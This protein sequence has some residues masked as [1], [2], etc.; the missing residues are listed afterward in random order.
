MENAYMERI[1][2]QQERE[3]HRFYGKYRGEVYEVGSGDN[4]GCIR[5][6]VPTVFGDD[7]ISGWAYPASPY[8][9]DGYGL[10]LMPETGDPVW[11]EFEN[12]SIELPIW[13]GAWWRNGTLP[14]PKDP[15][16]RVLTSKQGMQIIFDDDANKLTLKHPGGASIELSDS[17]IVLQAGSRKIEITS[18]SV[19]VNDGSLEVT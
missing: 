19:S 16:Q 10:Y 7:V 17:G 4:A 2:A 15:S 1:A 11:I 18:S 12:G 8:A 14:D 3:E 5:A 9:G 6:K 13:T